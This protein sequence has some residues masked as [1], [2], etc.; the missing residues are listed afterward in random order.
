MTGYYTL[1]CFEKA[2][3]MESYSGLSRDG[4]RSCTLSPTSQYIL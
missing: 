3:I 2:S 1:C 4:D